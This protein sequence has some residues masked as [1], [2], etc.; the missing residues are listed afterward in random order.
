MADVHPNIAA[1]LAQF[2]EG[3]QPPLWEM[4]PEMGRELYAAMAT[5]TDPTDVPIGAVEDIS[6]KGPASDVPLRV[7]TPIAAAGTGLNC[8]VFFHGG[9]F[10]I[11]DLNSHDALCRQLANESGCK[12]IAVDYR[13]APENPFPAAVDDCYAALEWVEANAGTLGINANAFA[14][15]GDSAGGN[16]SAVISQMARDKKGPR[17]CFQ[18]LIYP[19]TKAK[20]TRN[21]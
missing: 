8:L 4:G 19:S 7:Y 21:P 3:D 17:I 10:V 20:A 16:L 12:V 6:F 5:M 13:L 15:A 11:G 9:G 2:A 18:L 1:L 14:V